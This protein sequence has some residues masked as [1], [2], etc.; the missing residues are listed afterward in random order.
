MLAQ[1]DYV[2][3][4][5]EEIPI[6]KTKSKKALLDTSEIAQLRGALGTISWRAT[7]TGPQFLAETSLLLSEI[8]VA[9]ID[10]LYRVN[11][12]MRE[13]RREASQ[14]LLFPCWR[15]SIKDLAVIIYAD[16]SQRNRLDR[17][18]TI[19][20]IT[21]LGPREVLQGEECQFAVLQWKS[22]KTPRQCLGSNGA[23]IQSITIGKDQNYQI[24]MLLAEISGED[25]N[26]SSL[27]D[28]VKRIPGA[29]VMDSR[30]IY[31]ATT[32]NMSA[33]HGLRESRGY[34][35]LLAVNSALRAETMLRW[36]NG[37][38]QLGDGLT[39]NNARKMLLQFFSQKQ[40]WRLVDD[41]KF[42]AGR[43]V[44]K[45]ELEK[46]INE[47]QALVV[48]KVKELAAKENLPWD[49]GPVVTYHH[50]T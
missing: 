16:A 8:N 48:Q 23:E 35:L 14:G 40:Y 36:V 15:K 41:P 6:D 19:G 10:T 12:L 29:L 27:Y 13:M 20:I 4:W 21:L 24:R 50:L 34:E 5:I 49:E 26:R 1:E 45:R 39:K 31:D 9:T 44:H 32:R 18:S 11:R 22:G 17:S 47:M 25:I 38:S 30:G 37:M 42:E 3:K 28:V 46:K 33:L 2:L 43:K 7:Q